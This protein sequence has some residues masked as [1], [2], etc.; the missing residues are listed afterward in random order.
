[1]EVTG[2][3]VSLRDISGGGSGTLI[4]QVALP[5]SVA[6]SADASFVFASDGRLQPMAPVAVQLVLSG[7][8]CSAER[9]CPGLRV[10][11]GGAIRLCGDFSSACP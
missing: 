8:A 11:A 9:R 2:S 1:V 7:T 10:D 5:A 4:R 6:A 3:D